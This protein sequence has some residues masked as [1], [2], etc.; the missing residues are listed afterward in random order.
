MA[1]NLLNGKIKVYN[2]ELSPVGF[3]SQH[4]Q[5]GVFLRGREEDEEFVVE[6]VALDDIEAENTKSDIFKVGRLR[7]L[8]DEEDEIYNHLG[9][10][11]REN[12][13]SD[14]ELIKILEDGSI[15]NVTRLSNL[16]SSTLLL[17]MK[18]LLFSMEKNSNI[19][20]HHVS[21]IINAR[22]DELKYGGKRNE[23]SEINKILESDKKKNEDDKLKYVVDE[24]SKKLDKLEQENKDKDKTI[25]ES[26]VAIGEL[27]KMVNDLKTTNTNES[28]GDN[29]TKT[30]SKTKKDK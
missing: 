4:N 22:I 16:K 11:D 30:V 28:S 6:R 15:E 24:L 5:N 3:P 9:I 1:L 17:R 18:S 7:F 21:S 23:N 8:K 27:L 12:I 25:N 19:P 10:E 26:Q 13:K 29:S 20:P 14:S 2:Y